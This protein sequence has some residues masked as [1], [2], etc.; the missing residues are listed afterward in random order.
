MW[1]YLP[2]VFSAAGVCPASGVTYF[3]RKAGEATDR[4]LARTKA[5]VTI[6][7]NG[8]FSVARIRWAGNYPR[9]TFS[10]EL[11]VHASGPFLHLY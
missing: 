5:G 9:Y 4:T 11:E 7:E 3:A 2:L 8:G 10:P 1:S 6:N